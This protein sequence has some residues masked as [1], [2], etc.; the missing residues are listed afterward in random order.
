MIKKIIFTFNLFSYSVLT[1]VWAVVATCPVSLEPV[2]L[3]EVPSVVWG[4]VDDGIVHEIQLLESLENLTDAPVQ[5]LN[6]ITVGSMSATTWKEERRRY[7]CS[8]C[9]VY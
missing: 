8:L 3:L 4:E 1:S 6:L 9:V 5:L 2:L 7:K